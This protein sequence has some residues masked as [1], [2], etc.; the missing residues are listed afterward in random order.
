MPY[1]A[2]AGVGLK[3]DVSTYQKDEWHFIKK[4]NNIEYRWRLRKDLTYEVAAGL[5][6]DG[7][8][9]LACAKQMYVTLLYALLK[10][11]FLIKVSGCDSYEPRFYCEEEGDKKSF[12]ENE[13]FF[14]GNKKICEG[15]YGPG[16]HEVE[17]SIDELKG[18]EFFDTDLLIS[19]DSKL[20]F[21]N[22]DEYEFTYSRRAQKLLSSVLL[23]ENS[24][25]Y[26]MK[27]TIYCGILE[28]LS[29]DGNKSDA[30][31]QKID[32]LI[33]SVNDSD[34]GASDKQQLTNFLNGGKKK[35]SRQKC[36][37]LIKKYVK[38][39][40]GEHK[41]IDIFSDAYGVRST[42]S[43]GDEINLD[44]DDRS[45]YIKFVVLDVIK[46]FILE[47]ERKEC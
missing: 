17:N 10:G 18:Y 14:F 43:H 29:E 15:Q 33:A 31:L 2:H 6:D 7:K 5:F 32:E 38:E 39:Q 47:Q 34:L 28:H 1:V 42:F 44:R 21:D 23:A 41:A 25:D 36:K 13:I 45:K 40:Y 26:G 22:V 12:F 27:M 37:E 16:V 4:I 46:G 9:A 11:G 24:A 20:D 19:W 30:M 35:S 8:T 3:D